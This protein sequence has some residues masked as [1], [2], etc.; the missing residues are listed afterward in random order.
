[1]NSLSAFTH[2]TSPL[3]CLNVC[4]SRREAVGQPPV[5]FVFMSHVLNFNEDIVESKPNLTTRASPLNPCF[6]LTFHYVLKVDSCTA[7]YSV[8]KNILLSSRR[9]KTEEE[10]EPTRVF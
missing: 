5:H 1:M 3:Y 10:A 7:L 4:I 2:E 6:C 9:K 8:L